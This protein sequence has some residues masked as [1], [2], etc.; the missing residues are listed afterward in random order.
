MADPKTGRRLELTIELG[1]ASGNLRQMM[2]L[3]ADMYRKIG[4]VLNLLLIRGLHLLKN[5]SKSSNVSIG[6]GCRLS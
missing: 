6:M 4:I 3:M 2:E 1:S 5:E